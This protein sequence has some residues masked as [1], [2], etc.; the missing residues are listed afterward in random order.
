MP[1]LILTISENISS[2]Q[3]NF[4]SLFEQVHDAMRIIPE[5]DINLVHSGVIREIY[6]YIGFHDVE[7]TFSSIGWKMKKERRLNLS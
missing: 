3:I 5:L 4:H 1:Q 6:S 7:F 2:D